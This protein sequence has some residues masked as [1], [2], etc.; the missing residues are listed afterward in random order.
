MKIDK[1]KLIDLLVDKTGMELDAVKQQLDQLIER[2]QEA[3]QK[4]KA[5]EIKGFGMF[6][7]S[8]EG[9]LKFD[10]S[11]DLQTEV[12]FKYAGMDPVEIKKPRESADKQVEEEKEEKPETDAEDSTAIDSVWGFDAESEEEPEKPESQKPEKKKE[13]TEAEDE[14]EEQVTSSKDEPSGKKEKEEEKPFDPFADFDHGVIKSKEEIS[15]EEEPEKKPEKDKK[16]EKKKTGLTPQSFVDADELEEPEK[17][18]DDLDDIFPSFVDESKKKQPAAQSR[19]AQDSKQTAGKGEKKK[20]NPV[21]TLVT[22][23]VFV[24]VLVVGVIVAIDFGVMD[25]IFGD[26][27]PPPREVTQAVPQPQTPVDADA[28]ENLDQDPQDEAA[29]AADQ[30]QPE[31]TEIEEV[32]EPADPEF[33]LH[34]SAVS[35]DGRYY[36]IILHSMR[37]ENRAR[38]MR[39]ELQD[40]GYRAVM[41]PVESEEHG[42][43]WRIGVGQFETISQAQSAASE[44]PQNYRDNHFIGLIQ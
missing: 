7:F 4:G 14:S 26:A 23:I 28:M 25:S 17:K 27:E 24:L 38:E 19:A 35:I 33:G 36:S 22:T 10:P 18:E 41:N 21:Q 32:E 43:M 1:Q 20:K 29:D 31:P 2:I 44:L 9:E 37:N 11:D 39:D 12:N 3:A 5:L 6:Y 15:K 16:P 40:E 34:G 42:T 13:K 8:K 30:E